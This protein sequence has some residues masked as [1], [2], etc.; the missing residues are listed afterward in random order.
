MKS[1]FKRFCYLFLIYSVFLCCYIAVQEFYV[2]NCTIRGGIM[3]LFVS[4]P[5]CVYANKVLDM[6]GSQFISL[7]VG[8]TGVVLAIK[9]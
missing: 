1:I 6:I 3:N 9:I 2:E 7:F 5:M 8:L 4:M